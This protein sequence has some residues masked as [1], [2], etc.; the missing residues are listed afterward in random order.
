MESAAFRV[1]P[2]P[3]GGEVV[4]LEPGAASDA[5]VAAELNAAWLEHGLLLF[6]G[7]GSVQEHL[8]LSSVFGEPELHPLPESRDPD[9]P[10]V[11][12]LGDGQGPSY[13]YDRTDLRRGRLPWH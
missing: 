5:A 2:L 4:G 8:A 11:M 12:T 1:E 7:V 13:V 10:L 3:V 6:R 9:E